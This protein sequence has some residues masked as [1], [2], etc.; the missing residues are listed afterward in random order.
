MELVYL[1]WCNDSRYSE[2][3]NNA[4][5][6]N[7]YT[8]EFLIIVSDSTPSF[9]IVDCFFDAQREYIVNGYSK[10]SRLWDLRYQM[11][12]RKLSNTARN[13][14]ARSALKLIERILN[15]MP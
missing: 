1:S 9:M 5:F 13:L 10:F 6:T 15:F 4:L 8:N 14:Y 11:H 2:C 12:C 3:N 7:I